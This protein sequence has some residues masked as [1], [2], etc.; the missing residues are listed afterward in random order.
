MHDAVCGAG[1]AAHYATTAECVELT[2]RI[3]YCT[4]ECAGYPGGVFE[5]ADDI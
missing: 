2:L 5:K 1:L 4:L 3:R